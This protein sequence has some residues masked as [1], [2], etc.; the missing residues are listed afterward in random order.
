MKNTKASQA[1]EAAFNEVYTQIAELVKKTP[2]PFIIAIDGKTCAGKSALACWLAA[3]TGA[4]VFKTEDFYL[5]QTAQKPEKNT[6]TEGSVDLERF[7]REVILPLSKGKEVLYT[8]Y[9]SIEGKFAETIKKPAKKIAIV[10]GCYTLH[11]ALCKYYSFKIFMT[12]TP[13]AQEKRII[14]RNGQKAVMLFSKIIIP[15]EEEFFS[16]NKVL[17]KADCVI[18]STQ[19]W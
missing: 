4:D 18:D 15:A 17:S 16:N 19:L 9:N 11:K 7:K 13:D 3:K 1:A 5:P 8:A 6:L 14:K 10:K 12:I 2:A